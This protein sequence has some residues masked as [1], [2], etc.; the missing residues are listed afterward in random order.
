MRV[1]ILLE[2]GDDEGGAAAEEV[3][4]FDKLTRRTEDLGL[5]IADSKALLAALQQRLVEAQPRALSDERRCCAVCGRRRRSKGSY[6]IVF[7]TLFG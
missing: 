5:S 3:V 4:A 1:R 7:R 2:I 6:P